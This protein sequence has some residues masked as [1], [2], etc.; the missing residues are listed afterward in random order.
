MKR[1]YNSVNLE[2]IP[3]FATLEPAV[4]KA[5]ERITTLRQLNT[6]KFLFRQGE[7][8]HAIYVIQSG[9]LRLV[10]HTARGKSVTIKLYGAGEIFGLLSITDNL[11]HHASAEAI[12]P[13]RVIV[14]SSRDVK[15][16]INTYPSLGMRFI[17]L[18]VEHTHH[19]HERIRNLALED[20]KQRLARALV[21]MYNKF[22]QI[23]CTQQELAEFIGVAV[24]TVNRTLTSWEQRGWLTRGRGRITLLDPAQLQAIFT[25]SE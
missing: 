19:A 2:L 6:G 11:K 7:H 15:D 17:E 21:F 10:E 23:E 8:S 13:S 1:L 25:E 22:G 3:A 12:Q 5:L 24:E 9:G 4:I 20:A 16:L 18:L 14:A